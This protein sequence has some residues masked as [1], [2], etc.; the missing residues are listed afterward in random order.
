MGDTYNPIG[1]TKDY[2][3]GF[4]SPIPVPLPGY[5]NVLTGSQNESVPLVIQSR[6][7]PRKEQIRQGK[8]RQITQIDIQPHSVSFE[9]DLLAKDNIS[10]FHLKIALTAHVERPD[11]V[12]LDHITDVAAAVKSALLP[13]LHTKAIQYEMDEIQPLREDIGNWLKDVILLDSGIQLANIHIQLQPDQAYI[14]R[15]ENLRREEQEK[16]DKLR[17][18][19]ENRDY[20]IKRA[21]IAEEL[22]KVYDSDIA[23]VFAELASGTISPE[24]ASKRIREMRKNQYAESFDEK[25][26]QVKE[27]MNLIKTLQD[28]GLGSPD[29]L[30]QQADQLLGMIF[31]PSAT[32]L[33][34]GSASTP[35]LGENSSQQGNSS[36]QTDADL[37]APP[38]DD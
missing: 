15:K 32:A 5:A 25:M 18:L 33:N 22:G 14:K 4:F 20:E 10:Y 8:Y 28:N 1:P 13:E 30:A 35:T 6:D 2:E 26:R 36:G 23:Q 29:I 24:E 7:I 11:Q 17:K 21:E 27:V 38:S 37:Y 16:E 9:A 12:C 31:A 3:N 19:R 34:G